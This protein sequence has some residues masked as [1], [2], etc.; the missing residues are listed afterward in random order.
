M[1]NDSIIQSNSGIIGGH[2]EPFVVGDDFELYSERL[3]H[4]L[5]FNRVVEDREK[6]SFLIGIGGLE[7][8]KI[9]KSLVAPK[10]TT[11]ITYKFAIEKL[12]A[13]FKPKKNVR[14]ERHKFLS[15]TMKADED[16]SE[17][18]I[19]LKMLADTCEYG[20]N[21]DMILSDKFIL[22]MRDERIQRKLIESPLDTKFDKICETA[23]VMELTQKECKKI[24]EENGAIADM[25]AVTKYKKHAARQNNNYNKEEVTC[26]RCQG[27]AHYANE[28]PSARVKRDKTNYTKKRE[29]RYG[30]RKRKM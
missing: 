27:K 5:N 2:I 9:L 28:C 11:E 23:L 13:H 15:R 4:V 16:I 6:I 29:E 8:L 21:L 19:E 20:Q 12:S 30:K 18:I 1:P 17:F 22:S 26:Y 14:A 24:N 3:E 10:K 25:N 7:L